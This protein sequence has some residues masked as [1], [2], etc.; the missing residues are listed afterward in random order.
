ML[1]KFPRRF[2]YTRKIERDVPETRTGSHFVLEQT[3]SKTFPNYSVCTHPPQ[4]N[5]PNVFSK[6]IGYY[7]GDNGS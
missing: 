4:L 5:G 3:W 1:R 6:D 2:K 7:S